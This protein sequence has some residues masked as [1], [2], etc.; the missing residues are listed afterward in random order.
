[1]IF[2][3]FFFYRGTLFGG[4]LR[5][6][7]AVV[8]S[9]LLTTEGI[10]VD[11]IGRNLYWVDSNLDQIEVAQMNGSFRRTLVAGEMSSPRAI[12]L[13]PREGLLF[14][15][16][17]DKE[18]PRVERC[19][20]AGED[21]QIIV[22]V[23]KLAGAW[24]NGLT[25]DYTLKRVYWIDAR[26]DSIHTTD[27]Y[28]NDHHLV[29]NDPET[30]SHPFSISVFENHVYWTD[31]RTNSVIR[32]NKWNG[33]DIT[34]I[35]RTSSQPF[36]IQIL[37]SSRQP[38]NGKNPCGNNNGGCS[39]LCLLSVNNTFK[40]ACPHVMGLNTDNKTCKPNEQV[41]LFIIGSEIRGVDV[42]LPNHHT[43]PT[44]SHTAQ[45]MGPNVIDFVIDDGVLYW[46]D[47]VLSEIKS[48]GLANGNIDTILDTGLVNLS[49]FAIDW[50]SRNMYVSSETNSNSR[51]LASNLKGE[52]VT[53]IHDELLNVSSIAVNPV[54]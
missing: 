28:G 24:P 54:K 19:T 12:A 8:Q 1:M 3:N 50:I 43:I 31:W 10:A 5:N 2:F 27:Y 39:H 29:I 53:I 18:E 23:D 36:G 47:N 21:R 33:S 4:V 13:D 52:Y 51:I 49:G 42:S 26:S 17:W 16:D 7:E 45:V 25:L 34:V 15:T 48:S 22:Q 38:R 46:S 44:I 20:M 41:L 6:V 40:C 14:W 37:H 9:G 11:W 35:D 30:L 32:A